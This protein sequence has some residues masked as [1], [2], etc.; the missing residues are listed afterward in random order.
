MLICQFRY[1]LQFNQNSI[2]HQQICEEF[3]NDNS[4]EHHLNRMLLNYSMS[5]LAQQMSISIFVHFL[6]KSNSKGIAHFKS[7]ANKFLR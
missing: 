7:H 3:P 4:I 2:I 1:R 5:I 6:Y